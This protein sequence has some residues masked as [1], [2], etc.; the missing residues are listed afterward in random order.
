MFGYIRVMINLILILLGE[1][2]KYFL[3]NG[4]ALMNFWFI[5]LSLSLN[6]YFL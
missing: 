3:D 5:S 6:K 2:L 1:L 4:A